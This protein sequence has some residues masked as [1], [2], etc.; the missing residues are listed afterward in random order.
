MKEAVR[1]HE[2]DL[3]IF[4]HLATLQNGAPHFGPDNSAL[5][6]VLIYRGVAQRQSASRKQLSS[7]DTLAVRVGGG[8]S[9][10]GVAAQRKDLGLV[11][12]VPWWSS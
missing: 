9:D 11:L 7:S 5:V 4:W 1:A 3:I 12:L 10:G 6:C 2:L 8:D